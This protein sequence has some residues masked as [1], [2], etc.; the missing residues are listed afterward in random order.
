VYYVRR[1]LRE[2]TVADKE[3]F[4]D[5]FI[6]LYTTPTAEGVAKYG[7][8]YRSLTDL[9]A[10]HLRG[11]ANRVSDHM[12]DGLGLVTQHAAMTMEFELSM[13]SVA[14]RFATPYWDYTIDSAKVQSLYPDAYFTS[15]KEIFKNSELFGEDWF[16][17][18]NPATGYVEE[19]RMAQM[20]VPRDYDFEVSTSRGFLR[21][22]WNINPS[23]KVTRH[24][25]LCG[26]DEIS[27][28]YK[29]LVWPTCEVHLGMVTSST[30]STWCDSSAYCTNSSLSGSRIR[31][32][33]VLSLGFV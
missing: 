29:H 21:A 9:S 25:S 18:A 1:E 24:H 27:P 7:K 6:V 30:Y 14:P 13:Q 4:L 8:H 19:G 33:S 22:P 23:A 28:D 2:L 20:R 10:I 26:V 17:H 15:I 5:T 32:F 3:L 11:A 12:H 31:R 16:G